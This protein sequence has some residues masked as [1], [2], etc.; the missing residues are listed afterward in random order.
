ML[1]E[2]LLPWVTYPDAKSEKGRG[3]GASFAK[4]MSNLQAPSRRTFPDA[5]NALGVCSPRQPLTRRQTAGLRPRRPQCAQNT[6]TRAGV[7]SRKRV[8]SARQAAFGP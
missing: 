4:L 2:A 1:F 7:R 6:D 3:K 8:V 5:S